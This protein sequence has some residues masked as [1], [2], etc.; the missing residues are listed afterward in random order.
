MEFLSISSGSASPFASILSLDH[1]CFDGVLSVNFKQLF[2]A[3][4]YV[5]FCLLK[6]Q[7]KTFSAICAIHLCLD[8]HPRSG[9]GRIGILPQDKQKVFVPEGLSR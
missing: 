3:T 9:L 5:C 4:D 1:F 2:V 6:V 7:S 8:I